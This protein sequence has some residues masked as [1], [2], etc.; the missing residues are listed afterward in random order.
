MRLPY[1]PDAAKKLMEEAGYGSRFSRCS[2]IAPTT[3]ISTTSGC[4]QAIVPMLARIGINVEL[5]L[6]PA[7]QAFPAMLK[8]ETSFFLL[9]FNSPTVDPEYIFRFTLSTPDGTLGT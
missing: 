7:T 6:R 9:G 1:N 3:A 2:W 5:N 8:R 4:F